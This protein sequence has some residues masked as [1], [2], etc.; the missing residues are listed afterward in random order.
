MSI[1]ERFYPQNYIESA[2]D[3]PYSDLYEQGFRGAIF[4]I[5]NTLVKHDAPANEH[6]RKLFAELHQLGFK[7]MVLSN[8]G[9][10]RVKSFSDAVGSEYIYYA[11][12]PRSRNYKKAM[13][14]MGTD[15]D[16]TIFVGDQLFT[17]IWGANRVGMTNFLVKQIDKK[18]VIQIMIKRHFEKIVWYFYCR[19]KSVQ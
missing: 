10:R 9:E 5:D 16:T 17:D 19:S 6:A 8:N 13:K 3:I 2:Y 15:K 14:I 1:F 18:E 11:R 12:K 7:T 4:D